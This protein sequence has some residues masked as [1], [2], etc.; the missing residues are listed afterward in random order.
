LPHAAKPWSYRPGIS[1]P[2]PATPLFDDSILADRLV[3]ELLD[4]PLVAVFATLDPGGTIHAV[5]MWFAAD[6]TSIL[7]ATSSRSRKVGHLEA[8][9]RSTLV[10]HDSRPGFEVCGV[11]IAGQA[12]IVRGV[13]ADPLVRRVHRRYVDDGET[14]AIAREF[15][16]SDD[17]ALRFRPQSALT[18]DQRGTEAN[19]ALRASGGALPLLTTEPRS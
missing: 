5:P 8:D 9:P 19:I 14:P 3:A 18:W 11:S 1:D 17:V 4:A 13:E 15:L 12:E 16:E 7:L 2:I 10:I 6:G